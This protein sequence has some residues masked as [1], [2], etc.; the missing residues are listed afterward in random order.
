M[1]FFKTLHHFIERYWLVEKVRGVFRQMELKANI[2][3]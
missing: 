3:Q 1:H 2:S